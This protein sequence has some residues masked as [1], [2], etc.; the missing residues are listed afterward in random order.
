[1]SVKFPG[2][3]ADSRVLLR[4][5]L[6]GAHDPGVLD[7]PDEGLTRLAHRTVAQLAGIRGQ[8]LLARAY[9]FPRA[10]PQ[11][12]V[13]YRSHRDALVEAARRHAGLYPSGGVLGSIGLPDCI[14]SGEAA[15]LAATEQ[16]ESIR[17][18]DSA[19]AS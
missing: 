9:R 15:A 10:M 17:T 6:G 12:D 2:R 1:M 19:A 4:A 11:F 14:D 8:P 13:G 5:F 16:L 18:R 7:R 3:V